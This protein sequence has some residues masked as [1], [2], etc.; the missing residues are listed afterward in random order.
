[1]RLHATSPMVPL[2]FVTERTHSIHCALQTKAASDRWLL[3]TAD[4]RAASVKGYKVANRTPVMSRRTCRRAPPRPALPSTTSRRCTA[5]RGPASCRRRPGTPPCRAAGLHTNPRVR[6]EGFADQV[7][8]SRSHRD[9]RWNRQRIETRLQVISR[10]W[11][12]PTDGRASADVVLRVRQRGEHRS[13]GLGRLQ[14]V[15]GSDGRP[16]TPNKL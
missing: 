9:S 4:L 8:Y 11:F 12:A 15:S 3:L 13:R 10:D 1:M 7:K 16:G 6:T 14:D 2:A 5:R